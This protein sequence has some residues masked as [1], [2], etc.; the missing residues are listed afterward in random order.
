MGHA[1]QWKH[2]ACAPPGFRH[3]GLLFHRAAIRKFRASSARPREETIAV[4]SLV[5]VLLCGATGGRAGS[6]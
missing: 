1:R 4:I 2:S 3:A 5:V 6:S